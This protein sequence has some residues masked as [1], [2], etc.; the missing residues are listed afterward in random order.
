[1]D[2]QSQRSFDLMTICYYQTI[3]KCENIRILSLMEGCAACGGLTRNQNYLNKC[4]FLIY[5]NQTSRKTKKIR[6]KNNHK[7]IV[8]FR[9]ERQI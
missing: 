1:M 4:V 3:S 7:N 9:P 6:A 8:I 2:E 5:L